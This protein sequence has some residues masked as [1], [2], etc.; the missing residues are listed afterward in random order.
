MFFQE[1]IY[2]AVLINIAAKFFFFVDFLAECVI[3]NV[4]YGDTMNIG[5]GGVT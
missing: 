3:M 1:K 5:K 2:L 4:S